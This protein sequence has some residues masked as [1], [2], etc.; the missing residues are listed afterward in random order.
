MRANDMHMHMYMYMHMHMCMCDRKSPPHH[1]CA[2]V[3]P[4]VP[5]FY[6][7]CGPTLSLPDVFFPTTIFAPSGL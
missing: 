7:Y 4:R 6:M 3:R 2:D 5:C 1:L